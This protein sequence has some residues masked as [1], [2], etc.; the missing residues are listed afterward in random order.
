MFSLK[1][2]TCKDGLGCKSGVMTCPFPLNQTCMMLKIDDKIGK[3]C[4]RK[5]EC[6]ASCKGHNDCQVHC[7]TTDKCNSSIHMKAMMM[8][9]A[10]L[11]IAGYLM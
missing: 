3:S 1:C 9:V 11:T 6:D 7:C 2:Y 5:E 8:F 4:S 10:L